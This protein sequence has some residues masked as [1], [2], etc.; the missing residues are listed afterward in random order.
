MG[1]IYHTAYC[2]VSKFSCYGQSACNSLVLSHYLSA[3]GETTY[4]IYQVELRFCTT[5]GFLNAESNSGYISF[6]AWVNDTLKLIQILNW[7]A[8]DFIRVC[9]RFPVIAFVKEKL[10]TNAHYSVDWLLPVVG[11]NGKVQN[12]QIQSINKSNTSQWNSLRMQFKVKN[13]NKS[14]Q[15]N[16]KRVWIRILSR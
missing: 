1:V 10:Q 7:L 4:Y 12:L 9:G 6:S 2:K 16:T 15:G 13:A 11:V 3:W 14:V 5:T 8:S